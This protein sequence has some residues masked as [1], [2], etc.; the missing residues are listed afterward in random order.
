V[1]RHSVWDR[2]DCHPAWMI[3]DLP[4]AESVPCPFEFPGLG[5]CGAEPG[6]RCRGSA[7]SN[8]TY[9]AP[10]GKTIRFMPAHMT[11]YPSCRCAGRGRIVTHWRRDD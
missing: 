4:R 3:I 2:D 10:N 7:G 11:R 6:E 9:I 5:R 1:S 8:G